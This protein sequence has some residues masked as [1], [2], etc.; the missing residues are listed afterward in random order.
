MLGSAAGA[1]S[2]LVC[3]HASKLVKV[4]SDPK[5]QDL[6]PGTMQRSPDCTKIMSE[7]GGFKSD[8]TF[9]AKMLHLGR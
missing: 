1:D 3:R 4:A 6:V 8:G 9:H 5:L 7:F 2:T